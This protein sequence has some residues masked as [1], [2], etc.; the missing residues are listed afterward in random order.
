[1]NSINAIDRE[2]ELPGR[3]YPLLERLIPLVSLPEDSPEVRLKKLVGTAVASSIL[4]MIEIRVPR[5]TTTRTS[6]KTKKAMTMVLRMFGLEMGR[7]LD[8]VTAPVAMERA[9]L[10]S[11]LLA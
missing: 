8:R 7:S 11:A 6:R 3:A 10:A 9:T 1:M 4:V 2:S 5:T